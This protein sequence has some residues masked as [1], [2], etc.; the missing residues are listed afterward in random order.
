MLILQRRVNES[1][2]IGDEIEVRVLGV[3]GSQVKIGIEAPESV[4]IRR[5]ELEP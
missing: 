5:E 2:R 3:K 1:L 4:P